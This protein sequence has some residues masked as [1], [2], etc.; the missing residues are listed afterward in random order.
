MGLSDRLNEIS[1]HRV[2]S[3][4]AGLALRLLPY[5]FATLMVILVVEIRWLTVDS[6]TFFVEGA[7][8]RRSYYAMRDINYNDTEAAERLRE[9]ISDGIV[10]V[11]VKGH[12]RS[13]VGFDDECE[14]LLNR[15]LD[16]RMIPE[17]LRVYLDGLPLDRREMLIAAVRSI[18]D[19]LQRDLGL[20]PDEKDEFIWQKIGLMESDPASANVIFQ[21]VFA[22]TEGDQR[23]DPD[24]SRRV[25]EL[26]SSDIQESRQIFYTGDCIISKGE[27]VSPLAAQ[28][29]RL[30]GYPEGHYPWPYLFFSIAVAWVGVLWIRRTMGHAL[31]DSVFYGDWTYP[32]FLLI[33]GWFFE[34]AMISWG[35]NGIG[36]FPVIAVIYLSLP[37]FGGLNCALATAFSAAI[38]SSGYDVGGFS[39]NI[40]SGCA[41][42]ILGLALLRRNY[43]RYDVWLHVF[44]LGAGMTVMTALLEWG[45]MGTPSWRQLALMA[46]TCLMLSFLVIAL[47][48]LQE[49][50]FDIVSP[51]ELV[52]LTQPTHP[53]MK[54]LQ[55][56]A[57][58]TYHHCQMVGNLAEGAAEKIGLNPMLL[59]AGACFHDIGKL[60]RPQYFVENQTAGVNE[61][62]YVSPAM[63]AMIILS[64]VKDGLDLADEYRLP[65][66]IKSFIGEHHGTTCLTYFYKKALMAGLKADRSQFCYPGPSPQSRETAVLMLADS[67]EAAARADSSHLRG[68]KDMARLVNSVVQSKLDAGQLEDVPF[69]L[70]DISD[71]KASFVQTLCSMYHTRDIKPI[72]SLPVQQGK[73][74]K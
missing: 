30:Q 71:I 9:E 50:L 16:D 1:W 47:L 29:L 7:P 36:V 24:L 61:H 60:K 32:Y 14:V 37:D 51:L 44:L 11:V 70:K 48:P 6:A 43:S 58:G 52:E 62:D 15:P 2:F 72:R 12:M 42:A 38:V 19:D 41:G 66:Q 20:S 17:E 5:A 4:A 53:L 64:H 18:R 49:A 57:P 33:A 59:R 67:T 35:I 54:R 34:I 10:G 73:E 26:A 68:M 46:L 25:K 21:I 23:I 27:I 63:S 74:S 31:M 13:Q 56:E 28:L 39:I 69:T 8:A 22:L 40:I 65:S 55:V 45:L 3:G